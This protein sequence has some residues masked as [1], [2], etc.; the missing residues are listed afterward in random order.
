MGMNIYEAQRTVSGATMPW[1]NNRRAKEPTYI[2][3]DGKKEI[4][5][6]LNCTKAEC[7]NCVC[8][9]S[10]ADEVSERQSLIEKLSNQELT[11][12]EICAI[13]DI[14]RRTYYYYKERTKNNESK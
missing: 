4:M 13:L 5:R 2:G 9:K 12:K 6:C 8:K 1:E 14:S 11:V 7:D 3:I 10:K